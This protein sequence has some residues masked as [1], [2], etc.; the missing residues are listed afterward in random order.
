MQLGIRRAFVSGICTLAVAAL[1]SCKSTP[2]HNPA[3]AALKPINVVL[4][5]LDTVRADH[6]HCYGNERI[7]T[8]NIDAVAAGG[9]LFEK[10]VAQTPLTQP[11]HASMFTGENPNVH[12]VRDTGGFALQ[13]SSV[14]MATIL[15]RH[16][17]DTA[18]FISASVLTRLFGFNQGFATYDDQLDHRNSRDPVSTRAANVTADHAIHWLQQQSGKPFF[19]WVHFYD[20]HFPYDPPAEF[21]KQYPEDPYDA[22]IAFEDQQVGRVLDA[23]KQKSPAQKTLIIL[24]SDHGEGLGDHGEYDHGVFL[25]DSTVRIA[26]IMAGPGVPAGVQVKQQAR[27]IDLLPTVLDLMGGHASPAVQGTSLVPAFSG[28]AVPSNYS[29]EETLYPKINMG[30]SELRGIHTAHWMYV[31]AP[32]PELY[33]LDEDPGELNNVI[34]A[35]PKEYRELDAQLK[36]ASRLGDSDT[37]TVAFKQMDEQTMN[38]LKSLG[39]TAGFSGTSFKLNGK[40]D[41][42]KDHLAT[43]KALHLVDTSGLNAADTERDIQLL[44]DALKQDPSNPTLY[45][46]LVDKYEAAGQYPQAMQICQQALQHTALNGMILSR[47]ANLYLRTGNLKEAI[48][49]YQQAEQQNPL[50][51]ESQNDLATAYLQSGQLANAERV[52]HWVLTIQPYAPAYNGLGIIADKRNDIAGARAN[53]EKAVQ[54][55]PNYVEGQLNLGIICNQ[56][57][58]I[59]CARSA[60]RAF[61]A[62]A[63]RDYGPELNQAKVALAHMGNGPS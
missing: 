2:R 42:P 33:D 9:V 59:P 51:I 39:Y 49:Y 24:L 28:K 56:A 50:D 62:N 13:P 44:Q 53:F 47:L 17:W 8:P 61:V 30:W 48:S 38:Q 60:F 34:D 20:A 37:E 22:E 11:S 18:G 57:H 7:K 15:Q 29:Y 46:S 10:A 4:I 1:V 36:K 58:D 31:R 40:G 23:V 45:E 21:R 35:H 63:P 14:T 54:L 25:Y 27:E 19:L 32:R 41:D 3:A 43:L 6:L 12:N 52:F 55:S 26:W 16:G 5:T